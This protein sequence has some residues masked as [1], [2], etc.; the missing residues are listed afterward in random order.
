MMNHVRSY[1]QEKNVEALKSVG[2]STIRSHSKKNKYIRR[3]RKAKNS[4]KNKLTSL[5]QPLSKKRNFADFS[6]SHP[7]IK[8]LKIGGKMKLVLKKERN[9]DEGLG[10]FSLKRV[11]QV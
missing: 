11:S 8:N 7:A 5:V 1:Y 9:S 3:T 4:G 10:K 6:E 2:V